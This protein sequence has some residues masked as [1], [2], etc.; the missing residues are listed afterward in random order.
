MGRVKHKIHEVIDNCSTYREAA[1]V[2][3]ELGIATD[4]EMLREMWK[5]IKDEPILYHGTLTQN[6]PA[7]QKDGLQMSEGW[8]GYGM[9]G[10]FLS[11]TTEGAEYWAKLAYQRETGGKPEVFRFDRQYGPQQADLLTILRVT[12]PAEQT[13]LLKADMEQAEDVGFEGELEDWQDSLS[14]IGDVVYTETVPPEWV[15]F[16]A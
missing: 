4:S 3:E 1:D 15:E 16:D 9:I 2:L 6:L 14:E 11:A 10:V 7:I 12:I 8:G 5:G 13:H